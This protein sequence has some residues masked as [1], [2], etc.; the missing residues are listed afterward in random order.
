MSLDL[1]EL[2]Q[3]LHGPFGFLRADADELHRI[4]GPG[5]IPLPQRVFLESET[6]TPLVGYA[7]LISPAMGQLREALER[8]LD[9][10]TRLQ[11]AVLGRQPVD[12]PGCD[13]AWEQY[14]QLLENFSLNASRASYGRGYPSVF[15]MYHSV[16]VARLIKELPRRARRIDLD[17]GRRLGD[18]IKYRVLERLLDRTFSVTQD[19]A[20]RVSEEIEEPESHLFPSVLTRM[21]DNVL[22]LSEDHI[23]TDLS[24][25]GSYFRGCLNLDFNDFRSRFQTTEAWHQDV[26][27][28][29]PAVRSAA[30]NLSGSGMGEEPSA[31]LRHPGYIAHLTAHPAYDPGS[32]LEP[33]QVDIWESLLWRLKEFELLRALRRHV[34]P[35]REDAGRYV[36]QIAPGRSTKTDRGRLVLSASTRPFDFSSP[37]VVDPVVER[38]G[39][40]YD[41]AEFSAVL[42]NLRVS[43]R[44]AE[45][46]SYR[47]ILHLQRHANRIARQHRLIL[48]KYLGD[49]A[50]YAGRHPRRILLSAIEIQRLYRE[51]VESGLPFDRGLRIA[52]NYGQYRLLPIEE[53]DSGSRLRYEFFGHGIVELTRLVTGKAMREMGEIRTLLIS[54]GYPTQEVDRFFAPLMR[55]N[56]DVLEADEEARDF[57]AYVNRTGV[58]VNE[59]IVAT[60]G[61]VDRLDEEIPIRRIWKVEAWDRAFIAF[62]VEED[63]IEILV[64]LR[65]LGRAKF[66][67]LEPTPVFEIVD[68]NRWSVPK[69]ERLR[70]GDLQ[71]ALRVAFP[72]VESS[73]IR[74]AERRD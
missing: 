63:G 45:D 7:V 9:A 24:E 57:H 43:G 14:R 46:S 21:R 11:I 52:M 53:G 40:I 18:S 16:A 13:Q 32:N 3:L 72:P 29:D 39:L 4:L 25:L 65:P 27:Q 38:F 61:F 17:I 26:W 64:G 56:I 28:S 12:R 33:D 1:R 60:G 47:R 23:S 73:E 10:E 50:L 74:F 55:Q 2:R 22:I 6:A 69:L 15:W 51:A 54:L 30:E 36:C 19:V 20:H 8:Y 71:E 59:G 62:Q 34:L 70:A 35:V 58:L 41:I 5:G 49:G 48:E 31:F 37:W 68:G 67:G 42:S 44:D 66:K